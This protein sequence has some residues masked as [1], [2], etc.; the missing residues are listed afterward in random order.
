MTRSCTCSIQ[1]IQL[2]LFALS[3]PVVPLCPLCFSLRLR[4]S[5]ILVER[6]RI[7]HNQHFNH[8]EHLNSIKFPLKLLHSYQRWRKSRVAEIEKYTFSIEEIDLNDLILKVNKNNYLAD[9]LWTT[10]GSWRGSP[11]RTNLLAAVSGPMTASCKAW[12]ASSTMHKSN[13]RRIK[14]GWPTLRQ[15]AATTGTL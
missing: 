8:H 15:V 13:L 10:G 6:T 5:T 11:T 14:A 7:C 12:A 1:P 9:R 4:G 2:C 3:L